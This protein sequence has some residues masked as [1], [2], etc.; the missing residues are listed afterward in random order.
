[1]E[2]VDLVARSGART[3]EEFSESIIR[4]LEGT[5]FCHC[6][7]ETPCVI[8]NGSSQRGSFVYNYLCGRCFKDA[9]VRVAAHRQVK[10]ACK[11]PPKIR[12]GWADTYY[13]AST[14]PKEPDHPLPRDPHLAN[15]LFKLDGKQFLPSTPFK[16][17]HGRVCA[18]EKPTMTIR[19]A[20]RGARFAPY[21]GGA[22]GAS[23]SSAVAHGE[24]AARR[25]PRLLKLSP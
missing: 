18:N 21:V 12:P 4:E 1:M 2:G 24:G 25:G 11:H 7:L 5:D 17:S 3:A 23:S 14:D 10:E 13:R 16:D 15:G 22:T 19:C 20:T 9:T 8:H 6:P